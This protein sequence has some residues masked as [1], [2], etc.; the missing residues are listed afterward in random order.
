M[1]EYH[2]AGKPAEPVDAVSAGQPD[3]SKLFATEAADGA[4]E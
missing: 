3:A 4:E 2:N 1:E